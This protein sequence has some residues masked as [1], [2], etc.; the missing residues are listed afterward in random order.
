MHA[1]AMQVSICVQAF[2]SLHAKPSAAFGC[3][4]RPLPGSH[5]PAV[6]HS[7]MASQ[8]TGATPAHMPEKQM[9]IW[10]QASSSVQLTPSSFSGFEH[11]PVPVSQRPGSWH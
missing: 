9:S 4:H 6:W 5:T 11:A 3:E 1:P 2:S 8:I 10:V 7:S